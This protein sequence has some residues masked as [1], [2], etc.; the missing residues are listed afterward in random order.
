M[1]VE[2][3][4]LNFN[5][6]QEDREISPGTKTNW[7]CLKIIY[8]FL[9]PHIIVTRMILYSQAVICNAT[10]L[11]GL[12]GEGK[13]GSIEAKTE[14]EEGGRETVNLLP[15]SLF[16]SSHCSRFLFPSNIPTFFS[17]CFTPLLLHNPFYSSL[18]ILPLLSCAFNPLPFP[19]LLP[20]LFSLRL[21]P[22]IPSLLSSPPDSLTSGRR[23][24]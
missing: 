11:Q 16:S 5:Y 6:S 23:G 4:T 22:H 15:A 14:E 9:L 12:K 20:F 21:L 24:T 10:I 3:L 7:I 17:S 2:G 18:L 13:M 1:D 19:P 8:I